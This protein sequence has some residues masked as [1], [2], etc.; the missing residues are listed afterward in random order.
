VGF[1]IEARRIQEEEAL[2]RSYEAQ[3]LAAREAFRSQF[4]EEQEAA[5]L[6]LEEEAQ[7]LSALRQ[8]TA[9]D[10]ADARSAMAGDLRQLASLLETKIN[11]WDS[12]LQ[13]TEC[14]ML[15]QSYVSLHALSEHALNSLALEAAATGATETV[16]AAVADVQQQ[17]R[18]RV[19]QLETAMNRLGLVI[20][21]PAAGESYNPA[22]HLAQDP[23]PGKTVSRCIQPGVAAQGAQEAILRA[24]VELQ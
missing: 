21:R 24:E 11:A 15:A 19:R 23:A 7:S 5:Q 6:R 20:L 17:L 12:L 13:R 1:A 16:L 14:R 2:R 22:Y 4:A 18:D 9:G 8:E 3:Q 10:Y